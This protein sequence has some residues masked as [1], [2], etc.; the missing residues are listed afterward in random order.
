M[1]QRNK[2]FTTK[3]IKTS[4]SKSRGY[5]DSYIVNQTIIMTDKVFSWP[6]WLEVQTDCIEVCYVEVCRRVCAKVVG[7]RVIQNPQ[8]TQQL[9]VGVEVIDDCQ[10]LKCM[11]TWRK[12]TKFHRVAHKF[13]SAIVD[14]GQRREKPQIGGTL[15]IGEVHVIPRSMQSSSIIALHSLHLHL[16]CHVWTPT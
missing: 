7:H 8:L 1:H 6:T 10:S 13:L 3:K 14:D 4:R 9:H 5:L 11:P 15:L 2:Q 16:S 12:H